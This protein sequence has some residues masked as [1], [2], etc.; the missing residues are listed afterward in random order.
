MPENTRMSPEAWDRLVAGWIPFDVD[1]MRAPILHDWFPT[2]RRGAVVVVGRVSYHHQIADGT[3]LQTTPVLRMA[4]DETWLR[5]RRE[6]YRLGA[7]FV[8]KSAQ[9]I[10]E[11]ALGPPAPGSLVP[12]SDLPQP[13]TPRNYFPELGPDGGLPPVEDEDTSPRS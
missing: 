7:K 1:L 13:G 6:Y 2:W 3:V 8:R 4:G 9:E 12:V 5:T 11:A 10:A